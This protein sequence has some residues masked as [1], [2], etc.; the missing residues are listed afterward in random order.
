MGDDSRDNYRQMNKGDYEAQRQ[1]E[2][3]AQRD[4]FALA[5]EFQ[6]TIREDEYNWSKEV[7]RRNK[8]GDGSTPSVPDFDS[9]APSGGKGPVANPGQIARED[10]EMGQ[11]K[12]GTISGQPASE[13]NSA[14]PEERAIYDAE[15]TGQPVTNEMGEAANLSR[16][17]V[18]HEKGMAKQTEETKRAGQA[19]KGRNL[20]K[21]RPIGTPVAYA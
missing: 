17:R 21:K 3:Q 13:Y 9:G 19:M 10:V 1:R 2:I 16:K 14:T 18:A 4:Q 8:E 20:H 7:E 6:R 15:A 5:R 12:E 11:S